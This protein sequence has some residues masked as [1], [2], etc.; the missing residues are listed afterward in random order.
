MSF[1][2]LGLIEALFS[3]TI[4]PAVLKTLSDGVDEA[5]IDEFFKN[6]VKRFGNRFLFSNHHLH[7]SKLRKEFEF[8]L[9]LI[10]IFL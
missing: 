3:V 8:F 6:S 5:G 2:E 1:T 10:L 4:D 7:K 9:V